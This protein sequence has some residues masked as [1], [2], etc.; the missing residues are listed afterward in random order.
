MCLFVYRGSWDIITKSVRQ[1]RTGGRVSTRC[2][3][4]KA[5]LSFWREERSHS[6]LRDTG[7]LMWSYDLMFANYYES[8]FA[9]RLTFSLDLFSCYLKSSAQRR[10]T[11]NQSKVA[12]LAVN[13]TSCSSDRSRHGQFHHLRLFNG[14]HKI[15]NWNSELA[16]C[17]IISF[18]RNKKIWKWDCCPPFCFKYGPVTCKRA[19]RHDEAV[20]QTLLSLLLSQTEWGLEGACVSLR[21]TRVLL[22]R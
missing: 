21:Y 2:S 14:R 15:C 3:S 6:P 19:G 4:A 1:F 17:G 16:W 11:C 10:L 20:R 8:K 5:A 22:A 12:A 18:F 7:W 9:W 13:L